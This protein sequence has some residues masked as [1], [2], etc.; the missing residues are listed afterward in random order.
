MSPALSAA[1]LALAV[2]VCTGSLAEG[3]AAH[4]LISQ[5]QPRGVI[6]Q[7]GEG[8][9]T[10]LSCLSEVAKSLYPQQRQV[11]AAGLVAPT[12]PRLARDL[13]L[14]HRTLGDSSAT[15]PDSPLRPGLLNLP[16]PVLS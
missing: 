12:C 7:R 11:T 13:S 9:S 3:A 16:P 6:D 1:L 15:L 4:E 5:G 10:L 2:T 8:V 14:P